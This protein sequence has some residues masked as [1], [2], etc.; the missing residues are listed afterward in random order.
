MSTLSSGKGTTEMVVK[1]LPLKMA[2]AKARMWPSSRIKVQVGLDM[3][4]KEVFQMP[5]PIRVGVVNIR[6][7]EFPAV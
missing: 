1:T 7:K 3:V 5:T 2:N 6:L 4:R